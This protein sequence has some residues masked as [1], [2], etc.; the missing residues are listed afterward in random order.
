MEWYQGYIPVSMAEPFHV[1]DVGPT[2]TSAKEMHGH[3]WRCSVCNVVWVS[4]APWS[5]RD[6]APV[7]VNGVL[8]FDDLMPGRWPDDPVY[9]Q[10]FPIEDYPILND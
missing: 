5:V 7:Y 3:R 4:V 10:V 8:R 9:R 6:P 2:V 1:C